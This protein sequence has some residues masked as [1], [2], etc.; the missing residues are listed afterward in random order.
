MTEE[1]KQEEEKK[2]LVPEQE[3]YK[4]WKLQNIDGM[5][6][7]LRKEMSRQVGEMQRW[8]NY[9]ENGDPEGML[10]YLSDEIFLIKKAIAHRNLYSKR[11]IE[12]ERKIQGKLE[13]AARVYDDKEIKKLKAEREVKQNEMYGLL[14]KVFRIYAV[15]KDKL[16]YIAGDS[17]EDQP[18]EW[19][20]EE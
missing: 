4:Q 17:D 1:V 6:E 20:Y 19:E 7:G 10:A 5:I 9:H 18:I 11:K 13:Q 8:K 14:F 16:T 12:V 3:F 15:M 2:D